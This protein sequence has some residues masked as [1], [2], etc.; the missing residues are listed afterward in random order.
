M[1][2][3]KIK[4]EITRNLDREQQWIPVAVSIPKLIAASFYDQKFWKYLRNI[5]LGIAERWYQDGTELIF[6]FDKICLLRSRKPLINE[7]EVQDYVDISQKWIPVNLHG[8][9]FGNAKGKGYRIQLMLNDRNG[10]NL[11]TIEKLLDNGLSAIMDISK[12]AKTGIYN[13]NV[14]ILDKDGEMLSHMDKN[15]R[16]V[17]SCLQ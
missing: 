15:I 8:F 10:K 14:K 3:D 7:I 13:M 6:N 9:G 2:D 17:N 11:V 4:T 16:V 12:I 1:Y 5:N